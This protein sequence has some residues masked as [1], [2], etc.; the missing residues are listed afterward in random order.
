MAT[1]SV[2]L[3]AAMR[4]N[5]L[6]LQKTSKQISTTQERLSTGKKVN[7]AMDNPTNYF[8]A[9]SLNTKSAALSARLDGMSQAVSTIKAASEGIDAVTTLLASAKGVVNTAMS[10]T[11]SAKRNSLGD[12]FNSLLLQIS[13][14]SKDAVYQGVNLIQQAASTSSQELSNTGQTMVVQFAS[15]FGDSTLTVQGF[16]ISGASNGVSASSMSCG[17]S[18]RSGG[19]STS[20]SS[21]QIHVIL[22][23]NSAGTASTSSAIVEATSSWGTAAAQSGAINWGDDGTYQASLG[24]LV[25]AMEKFSATLETQTSNLSNSNS[26]ITTRQDNTQNMINVLT[27]GADSLTLADTNE[28]AA[29]MLALQTQQT[30]G[31]KSLSLA[32]QSAQ[33]VLQL[34]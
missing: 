12:Q 24:F 16:N 21:G 30:L 27:E 9:L 7:S 4:S 34:F 31:I 11:D 25:Q 33:S 2:S 19:K 26:T 17:L 14:V 5:L 29:N 18:L 10:T 3:T 20:Y 8:A 6:S 23:A 15:A 13:T 1:N 22:R 32:S 28:E